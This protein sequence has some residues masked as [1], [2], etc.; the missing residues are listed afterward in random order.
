MER[1]V[2]DL[3]KFVKNSMT[4]FV[5]LHFMEGREH[6]SG[7]DL[8]H[9]ISEELEKVTMVVEDVSIIKDNYSGNDRISVNIRMGDSISRCEIA[10]A[11]GI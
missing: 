1:Y 3:Q 8:K 4:D 10:I 7:C 9:H 6:I 11:Q 5:S 2:E